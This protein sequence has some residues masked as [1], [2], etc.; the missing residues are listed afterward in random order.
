MEKEQIPPHPPQIP[1]MPKPP[2][3]QNFGGD[4]ARPD[5][6]AIVSGHTY[7]DQQYSV[8]T[9]PLSQINGYPNVP[10]P[11]IPAE[12]RFRNPSLV[13]PYARSE[14]M[15]HRGRYSYASSMVSTVNGPRKVRR[16]KDPTP[17]K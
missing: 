5:S 16:R 17:F 13:D 6:V 1:Q 9:S 11:P 7:T 12:L 3:I 15:T 4:E 2:Q 14:S 8:P 10:V